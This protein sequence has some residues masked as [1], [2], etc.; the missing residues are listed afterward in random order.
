MA[1]WYCFGTHVFI[2]S[3][4][5]LIFVALLFLNHSDAVYVRETGTSTNAE[6]GRVVNETLGRLSNILP[7]INLIS[8][9]PLQRVYAHHLGINENF[10]ER[11]DLTT[12]WINGIRH[13]IDH[14]FV[15]YRSRR[16][17]DKW[18]EKMLLLPLRKKTF[19]SESAAY[20]MPMQ[21][22]MTLT[23]KFMNAT[24][25]DKLRIVVHECTHIE[26]GAEDIAYYGFPEYNSLRGGSKAIRNA[27]SITLYILNVCYIYLNELQL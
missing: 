2:W 3:W 10:Q 9:I 11:I 17:H 22:S 18:I 20:V 8:S 7:P 5:V 24:S 13:C 21:S 12:K 23:D 6:F 19:I 25:D 26:L 1:R 15:Y 16:R 4:L 27:D 14:R